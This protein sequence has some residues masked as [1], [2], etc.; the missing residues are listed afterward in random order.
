M[1]TD[2]NEQNVRVEALDSG[3]KNNMARL[4]INREWWVLESPGQAD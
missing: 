2:S 1:S 4:E 3:L